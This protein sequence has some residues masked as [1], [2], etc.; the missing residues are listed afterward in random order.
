L[1]EENSGAT[2][3]YSTRQCAGVKVCEFFPQGFESHTEINPEGHLWAQRL[4]EQERQAV[5]NGH[6]AVLSNYYGYKDKRCTKKMLVG[7]L[8]GGRPVIRS[9][10]VDAGN[11]SHE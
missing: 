10:N 8:C 1:D 6:D 11:L 4:A 9:H 3:G 7:G 2:M 5:N